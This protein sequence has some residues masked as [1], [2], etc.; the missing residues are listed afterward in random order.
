[1][2]PSAVTPSAVTPT[3]MT[4]VSTLVLLRHGRT[5]WNQ[6][7]RMQ[8]HT[9]VGLDEVGEAQS[10]QAALELATLDPVLL[11]SSDLARASGT[12]AHLEAAT[13]LPLRTD[14]R[15][16]EF[17]VGVRAGLTHAEFAERF[18]REY[19]AWVAGEPEPLVPGSECASEVR[20]RMHAALSEIL[21]EVPAGRTGVVVGHGAS[22][23]VGLAALLGWPDELAASLHGL[24]NGRWAVI[25]HDPAR[26]APRL[27][28]Y[29]LGR[30]TDAATA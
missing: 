11:V 13:G 18:P 20:E 6:I 3:A 22:L 10:R 27:A 29:N 28:G 17:D 30:C 12:A 21:A 7:Q 16:R 14:A 25:T 15:L 5:P 19:D 4:G 26:A 24:D 23:K 2:T 8:G 1:M 9:D